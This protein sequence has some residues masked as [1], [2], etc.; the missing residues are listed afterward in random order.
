METAFAIFKF[1]LAGFFGLVGLLVV[2]ALLFGKRIV[3]QWDYEAEFRNKAGREFGEFEIELSHVARKETVDTF[4]AKF[5][6][7]HSSLEAGQNV[8]VF[9]DDNL[10]MEGNVETPGRVFLGEEH[11]VTA[12]SSASSGQICRVA[13][14]G[15]ER[16]SQPIKPD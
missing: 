10:V 12:L 2:I 9:L 6:M 1:I 11:I 5:K 3:K 4:K 14:D 13:I 15:F 7:R 8:Q 16:F